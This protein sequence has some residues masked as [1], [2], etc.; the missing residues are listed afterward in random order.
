MTQSSRIFLYSHDT[1][2]LG[3]LRRNR[4]IARTVL[5]HIPNARIRLASG[6]GLAETFPPVPGL[7]LVRLP[8]VTKQPDG[9]YLPTDGQ[10]NLTT[11]LGRR[12][13][14]LTD[15]VAEFRPDIFISDKEPLGLLGELEQTLGRLG[16]EAFK[17]LGLRDVLDDPGLLRAEWSSRDIVW[18]LPGLYD[19]IWIYGPDWFYEPLARLDLPA[20]VLSICRHVGYLGADNAEEPDQRS[21]P[22]GAMPRPYILITAGGGEDGANLMNQVL[23]ACEC[24]VPIGCHLVLLFGPLM[25]SSCRINLERRAAKLPNI[26]VIDFSSDPSRLLAEAEAAVAMC[27]Y[28]TFCEILEADKPVLFIPRESPRKEQL[29]RAERASEL[30]VASVLRSRQASDPIRL[31]QTINALINGSKPSSALT[32][33]EFRGLDNIVARVAEIVRTRDR[34]G[35]P[36]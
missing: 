36:S 24:K 28:N 31:A 23:A 35:F 14:I 9:T 17:I 33:F 11:L 29:I 8:S 7:D 26:R 12:S 20:S 6:S 2:G 3:H 30:G 34:T 1:F 5:R 10:E 16:D 13:G 21:S 25:N 18:R 15:A 4:K 22:T 19:E 27:G 32:K